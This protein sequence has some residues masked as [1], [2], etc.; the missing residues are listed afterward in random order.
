MFLPAVKVAMSAARA[1]LLIERGLPWPV[2]WMRASSENRVSVRLLARPGL[3]G[4]LL[5]G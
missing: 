1:R 3:S 5:N 4:Q 2:S